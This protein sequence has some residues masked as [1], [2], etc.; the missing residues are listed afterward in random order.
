[1]K[2]CFTSWLSLFLLLASL[3]SDHVLGQIIRD[4]DRGSFAVTGEW[5][6]C[7][8]PACPSCV[9]VCVAACLPVLR[10]TTLLL[11]AANPPRRVP[12]PHL[13]LHTLFVRV[14]CGV[15]ALLFSGMIY[16]C[17]TK[18]LIAEFDVRA[19]CPS[20]ARRIPSSPRDSSRWPASV[21]GTHL[22]AV[23]VVRILQSDGEKDALYLNY[24]FFFFLRLFLCIAQRNCVMHV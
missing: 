2:M 15:C 21:G 8:C 14:S 19:L 9:C 3:P 11:H 13:L 4:D 18:V 22:L 7:R 20:F 10:W 24:W 17:P 23:C 16:M 6:S 12:P 5:E 1:M